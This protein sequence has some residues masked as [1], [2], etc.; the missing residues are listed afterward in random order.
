MRKLCLYSTILFLAINLPLLNGGISNEK[1]NKLEKANYKFTLT[2][3]D[4]YGSESIDEESGFSAGGAVLG[5]ISDIEVTDEDKL[6]VLDSDF[7]KIVVFKDNGETERVILGG[8]GKGPG[9]FQLPTALTMGPEDQIIVYDYNLRRLSFFSLEGEFLNSEHIRVSSKSILY[10]EENIWY[11]NLSSRRYFVSYTS[12]GNSNRKLQYEL[13]VGEKD[14]EYSRRGSVGWL[15][16]TKEG[17]ILVATERPGIWFKRENEKFKQYGKLLVN[18]NGKFYQGMWF[19]PGANRS[20]DAIGENYIGLL[21]SKRD[22]DAPKYIDS[23]W[24]EIFDQNGEHLDSIKLPFKWVS[25][26]ATSKDG[27][28]V[29]LAT[30]EPFPRVVKYEFGK[31]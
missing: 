29:Y 3:I 30:N 19:T 14:M 20:I 26:F 11:A 17:A 10:R 6:L 1:V 15:G 28:Y 12:I 5:N 21:W 13:P 7:K 9:E 16:L 22:M 8:M 23:F 27:R 4:S 2:E 31:N 24:L 18:S 25:T